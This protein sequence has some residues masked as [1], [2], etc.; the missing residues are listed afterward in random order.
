MCLLVG[1]SSYLQ[2]AES[3]L[4]LA[5]HEVVADHVLDQEMTF[6]N[7]AHVRGFDKKWITRQPT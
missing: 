5:I 2:R 6:F 7:M 3:A 4:V 1:N